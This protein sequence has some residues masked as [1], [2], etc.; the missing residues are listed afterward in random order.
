MG[1]FIL[2]VLLDGD[3]FLMHVL[4]MHAYITLCPTH[5]HT[6]MHTEQ[7]SVCISCIKVVLNNIDATA[8]CLQCSDK[9]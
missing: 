2:K 5:A 4:L 6:C 1:R 7:Q 3:F 9:M 8:M